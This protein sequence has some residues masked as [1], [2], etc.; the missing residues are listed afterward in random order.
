MSIKTK[1]ESCR[2]KYDDSYVLYSCYNPEGGYIGLVGYHT[3]A[4]QWGFTPPRRGGTFAHQNL[5]DIADFMG[6]LPKKPRTKKN[7]TTHG[8]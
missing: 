8:G 1:Y 3:R 7:E 6:R 5:L 4:K 2:F